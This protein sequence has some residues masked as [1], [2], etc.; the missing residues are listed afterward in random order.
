MNA[1]ENRGYDLPEEGNM[2]VSVTTSIYTHLD[3]VSPPPTHTHSSVGV[4]RT[5][6]LLVDVSDRGQFQICLRT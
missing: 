5:D 1:E 4:Q 6:L 3:S 2:A